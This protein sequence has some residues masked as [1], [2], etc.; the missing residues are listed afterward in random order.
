MN[1]QRTGKNKKD[2]VTRYRDVWGSRCSG[3]QRYWKRCMGD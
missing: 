2:G 1:N 3:E